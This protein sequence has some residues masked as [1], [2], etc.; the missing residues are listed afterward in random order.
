M[1]NDLDIFYSCDIIY[2]GFEDRITIDRRKE[3][4]NELGH[5]IAEYLECFDI[6]IDSVYITTFE[7]TRE[8]CWITTDMMSRDMYYYIANEIARHLKMDVGYLKTDFF[9]LVYDFK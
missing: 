8:E 1:K 6:F 2:D 7:Y 4:S 5:I 9:V 3:Y